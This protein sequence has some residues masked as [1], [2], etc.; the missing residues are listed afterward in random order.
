LV[1]FVKKNLATL[2]ERREKKVEAAF[3]EVDFDQK[4]LD[5]ESFKN[6]GSGTTDSSLAGFDPT[7]QLRRLRR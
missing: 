4:N 3:C 2:R 5:R 1:Y 7:T 6:V